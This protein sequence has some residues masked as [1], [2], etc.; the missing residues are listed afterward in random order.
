MR[1]KLRLRNSDTAV[2]PEAVVVDT[3][4]GF[5]Q[6][7]DDA[8]FPLTTATAERLAA[9]LNG[10]EGDGPWFA[11]YRLAVGTSL[12]DC[13]GT[14]GPWAAGTRPS[15]AGTWAL[16]VCPHCGVSYHEMGATLPPSQVQGR[17]VGTVPQHPAPETAPAESA[18][19]RLG[20]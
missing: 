10:M 7:K 1:L 16:G 20:G 14:G 12:A 13:P 4:D 19:P 9:Q 8:G 6:W 15:S 5:T 17:Y 18:T 3:R 2:V 11:V